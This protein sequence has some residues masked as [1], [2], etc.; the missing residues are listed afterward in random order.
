[1]I[2]YHK[3]TTCT[4]TCLDYFLKNTLPETRGSRHAMILYSIIWHGFSAHLYHQS[5]TDIFLMTEEVTAFLMVLMKIFILII[6]LFWGIQ[7]LQ[8]LHH[9]PQF[10]YDPRCSSSKT[11][12][13]GFLPL[14]CRLNNSISSWLNISLKNN[15]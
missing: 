5:S 14:I 4:T 2:D 12:H 7:I 8:I 11:S 13:L 10:S 9:I 6:F 1:M 3:V 15:P